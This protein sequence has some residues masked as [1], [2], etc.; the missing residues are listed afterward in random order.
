L[1]DALSVGIF[2]THNTGFRSFALISSSAVI[3]VAF[4]EFEE[5]PVFKPSDW[6]ILQLFVAICRESSVLS[7]VVCRL[8]VADAFC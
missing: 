1:F 8:F 4:S 7:V 5:F 3:P 6:F 2:L